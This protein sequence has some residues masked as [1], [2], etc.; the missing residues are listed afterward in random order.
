MVIVEQ[1]VEWR[2]AGETD[3]LHHKSQMTRHELKPW[4]PPLK[5][6]NEL[7]E[8]WHGLLSAMLSNI[9]NLCPSLVA[10]IKIGYEAV[11]LISQ[12]RSRPR[13]LKSSN[14]KATVYCESYIRTRKWAKTVT[15]FLMAKK[16]IWFSKS[17]WTSVVELCEMPHF[18]SKLRVNSGVMQLVLQLVHT[19][20]CKGTHSYWSSFESWQ[21]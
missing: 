15:V 4:P 13:R 8:L 21:I 9:L 3:V 11:G 14:V 1:L 18:I 12:S 5:A 20:T 16:Q 10:T 19:H 7:A 2:W 17:C 6:S